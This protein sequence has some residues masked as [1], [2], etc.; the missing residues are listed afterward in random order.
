MRSARRSS[1]IGTAVPAMQPEDRQPIARSVVSWRIWSFSS[2][3]RW[4]KPRHRRMSQPV[5]QA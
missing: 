1:N 3:S 4:P 2:P 5:P